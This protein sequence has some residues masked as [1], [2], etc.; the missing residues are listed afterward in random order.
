MLEEKWYIFDCWTVTKTWS[1]Y[2]L[3]LIFKINEMQIWACAQIFTKDSQLVAALWILIVIFLLHNRSLISWRKLCSNI[4][5]A[6]RFKLSVALE[7]DWGVSF[8]VSLRW[9]EKFQIVKKAKILNSLVK[10]DLAIS[11]FGCATKGFVLTKR[12]DNHAFKA[13]IK[14]SEYWNCA[15]VSNEI[16]LKMRFQ[17]VQ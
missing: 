7:K 15:S 16:K 9:V 14:I 11:R 2:C 5:F 10:N 1:R 8:H 6:Q 12:C 4:L 3:E 13:K 17:T